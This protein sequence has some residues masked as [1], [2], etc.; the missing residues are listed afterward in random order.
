MSKALCLR[1]KSILNFKIL[2][3]L[4]EFIVTLATLFQWLIFFTS[5]KNNCTLCEAQNRDVATGYG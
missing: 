3:N 4:R 2:E 1:N 5:T